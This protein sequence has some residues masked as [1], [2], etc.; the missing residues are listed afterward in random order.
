MRTDMASSRTTIFLIG[1]TGDL[2]R[3]KLWPALYRL[4]L[5]KNLT[6]FCIIGVGREN[7]AVDS[8]LSGIRPFI[9]A[10]KED[11]FT[12]L[13]RRSSYIQLNLEEK[14][15]WNS[16]A[17]QI[18][19]IEQ[20]LFSSDEPNRLVYC[21]TA[22]DFFCAITQLFGETKLLARRTKQS[23][24]W[25]RIV[26][27]KPFGQSARNA[28]EIDTCIAQFFAEDQVFRIDHYLSK[29]IVSNILLVRFANSIFEPLWNNQCIEE[30]QVIADEELGIEGRASYYDRYGAV[31][32]MVQNHMLALISLICLEKPTSM[33]SEQIRKRRFDV[34]KAISFADAL[35]GQYVGYQEENGVQKNSST[36]TFAALKFFIN[37]DR[38]RN[39]PFFVRV[40]KYLSKKETVIH[41]K[42]KA[43][44]PT[45]QNQKIDSNWLTIQIAP[46]AILRL[47]LNM[48]TPGFASPLIPVSMEFC[49]SCLFGPQT[50]EAYE[51]ILAEVLKGELSIALSVDE[52]EVS[53]QVAE[54]ILTHHLPRFSYQ[55]GSAGPVELEQFCTRNNM[56]WRS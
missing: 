7:V 28:Q 22:S 44:I 36:E 24:P 4:I 53:W 14:T 21:A 25:H 19:K 11:V 37:N 42:F 54:Q 51:Q 15:A 50:P 48:K 2:A 20:K 56:R 52:I 43:V 6:E 41:I 45:I 17:E 18:K 31:K 27:E 8:I 39:I 12:E 33:T 46:E 1:A 5:S 29:E 35:F 26:Y 55:K 3:R 16:F 9:G 30:V 38:W 32:D 23:S 47:T 10:V 13:A 49:H 40:G 34:L